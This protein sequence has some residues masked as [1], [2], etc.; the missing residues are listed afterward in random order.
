MLK[1]I[2]PFLMLPLLMAG[3][4]TTF[5]NLTATQQPRNNENLYP[6]EFQFD[7]PEQA[8]RWDSIRPS[9]AVDDQFYPMRRVQLLTN[10]W[11]GLLPVP[12]GKGSVAYQ[13]KVDYLFNDFG[14]PRSETAISPKYHL[15]ITDQ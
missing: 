6:V 11:E 2:F 8:L 3:C 5:S 4:S 9:I 1:K 13:Y 15:I 10:R 12:A 14:G 7:S